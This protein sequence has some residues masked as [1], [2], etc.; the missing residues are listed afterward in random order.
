MGEQVV[1]LCAHLENSGGRVLLVDLVCDGTDQGF[2]V[3]WGNGGVVGDSLATMELE[4][5]LCK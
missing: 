4:C 2:P 5:S 1:E 3:G